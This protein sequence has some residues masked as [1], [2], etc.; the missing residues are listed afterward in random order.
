M[1]PLEGR[2]YHRPYPF[3]SF[4][5]NAVEGRTGANRATAFKLLY[6]R[7]ISAYNIDHFI[8]N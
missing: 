8:N 4:A 7:T 3:L 6:M 2:F 1:R 5:L